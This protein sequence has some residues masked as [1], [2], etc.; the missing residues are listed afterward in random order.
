VLKEEPKLYKLIDLSLLY[1]L[2]TE[3]GKA[4]I[5]S[6]DLVDQI[7]WPCDQSERLGDT[8]G[9]PQL[10]DGIPPPLRP[11]PD[12]QRAVSAMPAHVG[13]SLARHPQ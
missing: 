2:L 13:A 9:V 10:T 7:S 5:A 3:R 6:D 4:A 12:S 11:V 8:R 1:Q